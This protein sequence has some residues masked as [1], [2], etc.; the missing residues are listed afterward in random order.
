MTANTPPEAKQLERAARNPRTGSWLANVLTDI[1]FWVP[2]AVLLGG[3]FLLAAARQ[4]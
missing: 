3:L 1:Q 4:P 2:L